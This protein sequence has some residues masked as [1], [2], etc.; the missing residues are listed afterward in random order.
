MAKHEV[1]VITPKGRL[2]YPHLLE[3]NVGG[4]FPSGEYE[5]L[6][7]INKSEDVNPMMEA[8][9]NLLSDAFGDKLTLGSLKHQPIKDGDKE[10][11]PEKKGCWVIKAKNE[12]KPK[13]V[14]PDPTQ[15]ITDKK[16]IYGG[17]NARLSVT[18]FAYDNKFGK[19]I[20]V[21]LRNVQL[22]GG[23]EGFGGGAAGDPTEDFGK[24]GEQLSLDLKDPQG[25][26]DVDF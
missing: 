9:K 19:G 15:V 16:L 21:N 7:L 6:L 24:V 11:E 2:S 14:G 4:N 1:K 8:L 5:T 20:K 13:V 12:Y 25:D 10:K 22:L 23:G 17:A 3:P 26:P 18:F